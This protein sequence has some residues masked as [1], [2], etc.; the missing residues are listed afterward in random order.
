MTRLERPLIQAG[1]AAG[2][3]VLDI[4]AGE[5]LLK[6]ADQKKAEQPDGT[7]T[8]NVA[9]EEQAGVDDEEPGSPKGQDEE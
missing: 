8:E 9:A 4:A 5:V 2:E 6:Q 3:R 1:E 7:V